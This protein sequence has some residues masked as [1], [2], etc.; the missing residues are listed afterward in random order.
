MD[1]RYCVVEEASPAAYRGLRL[2]ERLGSAPRFTGL[3]ACDRGEDLGEGSEVG[4]M[5]VLGRLPA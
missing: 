2:E 1:D 3:V 4:E 5:V